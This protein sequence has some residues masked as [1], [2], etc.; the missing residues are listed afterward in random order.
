MASRV[1]QGRDYCD[2]RYGVEKLIPEPSTDTFHGLASGWQSYRSATDE[3]RP[4]VEFAHQLSLGNLDE[5]LCV[6]PHNHRVLAAQV[7]ELML[8]GQLWMFLW[9][10]YEGVP[11]RLFTQGVICCG[12]PVP[13]SY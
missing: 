9:R 11:G 5:I 10:E 2:H 6:S 8:D 3:D 1:P 13:T 12:A 4:M 7:S